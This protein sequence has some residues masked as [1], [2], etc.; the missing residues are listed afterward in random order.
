MNGRK[1]VR[2]LDSYAVRRLCIEKEYYTCG[3]CEQYEN[4]FKMMYD[5][6]KKY[7]DDS[8]YWVAV[9]IANHSDISK[10]CCNV[11]EINDLI[12]NIWWELLN[13]CVLTMLVDKDD[14]RYFQ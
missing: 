1:V 12:N 14:E 5:I 10:F 3:D 9:D 4:M 13:R 7:N 6:N 2:E 11:S 8:V